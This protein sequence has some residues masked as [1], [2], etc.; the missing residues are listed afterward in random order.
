M[1]SSTDKK[2][3]Y[4]LLK[5]AEKAYELTVK[6][7]EKR[8]GL[9]TLNAFQ[10]LHTHNNPAYV[11]ALQKLKRLP[12]TIEEFV[13]SPE[14]LGSGTGRPVIDIWDSLKPSIY[15][16]NKDLLLGE[17][18]PNEV[19]FLGAS[20]TGKSVRAMVSTLYQ[21]Y[22]T[23]CFD[24]PQEMF[25]LSRPTELVFIL[26]SIK[27]STA[28]DVLYKPFRQYFESMPY[29]RK[30]IDFN[31]DITSEL[32]L[33]QN[34]TV[35]FASANVNSLI[36][37]AIMSGVIDEINYFARVE[38]SK[39]TPDGGTFDQADLVHKTL[40][41]RRE[42]R[43]TSHGPNPGLICISAQTKYKGD[44]TD[45][46]VEQIKKLE[47]K[48]Q[49]SIL[50]YRE[51]RYDVVPK[52]RLTK[53]TFKILVGCDEYPTRIIEAD[54]KYTLP[55]GAVIEE[56]PMTYY[57]TFLR[58]PEHGLREIVGI[59]SNAITPFIPQRH[60][61]HEA[62]VAWSERELQP[63]TTESNYR[64]NEFGKLDDKGMPKLIEENL[65]TDGKARYVH[66][67]L[68]VSS[69]RCGIGICHIDGYT[70]VDGER[71]PYYVV[72][73]VV[74]LEPDS[75]N[76]VDVAEV[77]RWVS[78]LKL[79]Y[80]L[81]IARVSYDGYQSLESLQ[82]FRKLGINSMVIS[83]DKTIEPYEVLRSAI[84]TNRVSLP[85]NDLLKSELAGLELNQNANQGK[86]KVDHTPVMGK[87]S[88]DAVCG[89]VFNAST[90]GVAKSQTGHPG[91]TRTRP[92]V[93]NRPKS[94]HGAS[95]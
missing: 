94:R 35:R 2:N 67:D 63:W 27:P 38:K 56:V 72:D 44:F 95:I 31:K 41:N 5:N 48:K 92:T 12:V 40:L 33:T 11:F 28:E 77:R 24:W 42:S 57:D 26:L 47:G 20:G 74:T 18:N 69:D 90:S 39:Q 79:K 58:D 29:T 45:R 21:L 23:D 25:Q 62:A 60:K 83:A 82:M 43:F 53:E 30:Y 15:E 37:H 87:D 54:S 3:T 55:P 51:K 88:A 78:N 68:S 22:V 36:A 71:L 49:Q 85:D 65:P 50:Y 86:G 46:R 93:T 9:I 4:Q 19:L 81:N 59:A 84:Y 6:Y 8:K 70:E 91:Y 73:W 76:Q 66:V 75:I 1:I 64:L 32:R 34:K 10:Q 52:E 13:N 80:G 61:I 14:F 17:Q 7:G 89:A 16:I